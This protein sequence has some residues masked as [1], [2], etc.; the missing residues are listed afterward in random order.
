M[1]VPLL[2]LGKLRPRRDGPAQTCRHLTRARTAAPRSGHFAFSSVT[3]TE[4][5][6]DMLKA[7]LYKLRTCAVHTQTKTYDVPAPEK[8]KR[9]SVAD[10]KSS[11]LP[12]SPHRGLLA[13]RGHAV[14]ASSATGLTLG[15]CT[16]RVCGFTLLSRGTRLLK[17]LVL[18][19]VCTRLRRW[20]STC[21]QQ[22]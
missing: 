15:R 22:L 7:R 18:G 1:C 12:D 9:L 11:P 6:T 19:W 4:Q 10:P 14:G 20:L 17:S 8:S 16:P 13:C 3:L 5:S 2:Q 21:P